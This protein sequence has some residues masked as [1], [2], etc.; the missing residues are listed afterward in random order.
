MDSKFTD[1]AAEDASFR[2][3]YDR[4]IEA[5]RVNG[6]TGAKE[7]SYKSFLKQISAKTRSIKDKAGC[8]AV[9]YSIVVK[10]GSVSVKAVPAGKT[11][12]KGGA[13]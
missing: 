12:K 13:K 6:G 11:G 10:E 9:T 1:P 2:V 5:N 8:D 4:Y 3:F 7:V